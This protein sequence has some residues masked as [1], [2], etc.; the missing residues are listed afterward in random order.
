MNNKVNCH[1]QNI[2]YPIQC[3]KEKCNLKYIGEN[4]WEL[5]DRMSEHVGYIRI[6]EAT[7]EHFNLI[8]HS[9]MNVTILEKMKS[10]EELYKKRK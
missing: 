9:H 8:G 5:K 6:S 4:E 1:T 7:G 2:I 3:T 10:Q